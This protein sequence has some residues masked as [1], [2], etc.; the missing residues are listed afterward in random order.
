[1]DLERCDV[2]WMAASMFDLCLRAVAEPDTF[3]QNL[4]VH[5]KGLS[6]SQQKDPAH[7]LP[8]GLFV[9]FLPI[10]RIASL[11]VLLLIYL[12]LVSVYMSV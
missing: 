2:S 10:C 5:S 1:M 11:S 9:C 6:L 12:V 8:T 7:V 4:N 3:T